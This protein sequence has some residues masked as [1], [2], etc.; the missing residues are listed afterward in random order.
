MTS[1]EQK[2]FVCSLTA[3]QRP[4]GMALFLD[5][6]ATRRCP[7]ARGIP[8]MRTEEEHAAFEEFLV[9]RLR[10]DQLPQVHPIKS[11]KVSFDTRLGKATIANLGRL[12]RR[13]CLAPSSPAVAVPENNASSATVR[14]GKPEMSKSKARPLSLVDVDTR[15][16]ESQSSEIRLPPAVASDSDKTRT[17]RLLRKQFQRN[18]EAGVV[19][20]GLNVS[21]LLA[22]LREGRDV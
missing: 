4:T 18:R 12:S 14:R 20:F 10:K 7:A 13:Q 2:K 6:T 11:M 17:E 16:P 19:P 15:A 3:A 8:F 9:R 21:E 5:A 22:R 1:L